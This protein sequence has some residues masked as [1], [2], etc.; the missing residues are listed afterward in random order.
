MDHIIDIQIHVVGLR[1]E[2]LIRNG[3]SAVARDSHS[4]TE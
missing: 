3:L 2:I 4:E 1:I